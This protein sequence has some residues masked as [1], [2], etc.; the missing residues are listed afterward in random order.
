MNIVEIIYKKRN[1]QEL[2]QAEI[3]Y[4]IDGLANGSV[5]DYQAS[6][7]LMAICLNDMSF[8]ETKHLTDAMLHSGDVIDL[9]EIK[10][11]TID[12]HSTGGVGDKTSLVLGP[13]LATYDLALAKM[14]GRGLGHTGGTLDKLE[15]IPG[16]S[17]N[18]DGEAFIKQVNEIGM[19]IIGQ[20]GEL[21]PADKKLYSLRDVTATVDSIPLIASSIMSKK[22]A[23]GAHIIVLDVKY[24][25]GAFM[26]T[27]EDAKHL[28]EVL[29]SIGNGLGRKT[30][31]VVTSME[32]PLG[33]NVGN[34]N[35][36]EEVI[37]TLKGNGPTDL[38]ELCTDLAAEFLVAAGIELTMD[39]AL[40][41]VRARL[42]TDEPIKKFQQF[43]IA[44]GAKQ[45]SLEK[46]PQPK[47]RIDILAPNSGWVAKLDAITVGKAAMLLGAGRTKAEDDIDHATGVNL[48]HKVGDQIQTGEKIATLLVNEETNLE[49]AK[50]MVLS[51][52]SITAEQISAQSVINCVVK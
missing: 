14:S 19:A 8:E 23:S 7:L 11:P 37:E 16:F 28:A 13:L 9:S 46:L 30:I 3:K 42:K 49:Q 22:L 52:F 10:L 25:S 31:A 27:V 44:Q 33:M 29:V 18:L 5:T 38:R 17:I 35:E 47:K 45:N 6:A 43:I 26:K 15:A 34:A 41:N 21:V 48:Y 50:E 36:I 1:K 24:G 32:Q 12:K 40:E 20:T 39:S 2:S 51:A 4:F